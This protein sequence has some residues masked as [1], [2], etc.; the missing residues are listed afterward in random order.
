LLNG[1]KR[2]RGQAPASLHTLVLSNCSGLHQGDAASLRA[3]AV[4]G[5]SIK[6]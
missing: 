3:L 4:P 6:F 2:G 5:L 1:I